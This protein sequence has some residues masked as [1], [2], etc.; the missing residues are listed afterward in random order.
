MTDDEIENFLGV[1][2]HE[3]LPADGM[4]K[5]E[6][7]LN[8]ARAAQRGGKER[9]PITSDNL[10]VAISALRNAIAEQPGGEEKLKE[11]D[12]KSKKSEEK[13]AVAAFKAS[14]A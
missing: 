14:R 7:A 3:K 13:A 10:D 5:L 2:V 4:K 8:S 11:I 6:D 1:D 9:A 12:D